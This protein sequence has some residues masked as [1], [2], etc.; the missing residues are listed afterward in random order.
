M[1]K[2]LIKIEINL[3]IDNLK[4]S[5]LIDHED[6][7]IYYNGIDK[8]I[9]LDCYMN[10]LESLLRIIL[11]LEIENKTNEGNIAKIS[12][13]EKNKNCTYNIG[14]NNSFFEWILKLKDEY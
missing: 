7:K 8:K 12:I 14:E 10:R 6:K 13:Y 1:Y 5:I 9:S 4:D 3:N 2:D 11:L